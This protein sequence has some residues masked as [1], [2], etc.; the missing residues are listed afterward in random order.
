M[1]KLTDMLF[2]GLRERLQDV[3]INGHETLRL[4]NTLNLC[5]PGV[6]STDLI[7]KIKD[8]VAVTAGS[9]CHSGRKSPS[10]VL[11]AMG[12]SEGDALS[13]VRLSTGKDNIEEEIKAAVEIIARAAQGQRR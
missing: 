11:M 4:P 6:D 10:P 9:A 5:I 3:R 1:K 13:S 2:A 12:M 8:E 7:E